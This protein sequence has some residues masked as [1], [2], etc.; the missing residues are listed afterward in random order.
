MYFFLPVRL[1]Q[2]LNCDELDEGRYRKFHRPTYTHK[3]AQWLSYINW[4]FLFGPFFVTQP[5]F[6]FLV[7]PGILRFGEKIFFCL[8]GDRKVMKKFSFS[9]ADVTLL[10]LRVRALHLDIRCN[11]FAYFFLSFFN[12]WNQFHRFN[13]TVERFRL[14][15]SF[16]QAIVNELFLRTPNG[17][18][19]FIKEPGTRQFQYG[20]YAIREITSVKN[21]NAT[22]DDVV[23]G[24]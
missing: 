4:Q 5:L 14:C 20:S 17:Q 22:N 6:V 21:R 2:W 12:F 3:T 11:S 10:V 8:D 18:I 7:E 9:Y 19:S 13:N 23:Y 1:V 15:S 24:Q 16:I